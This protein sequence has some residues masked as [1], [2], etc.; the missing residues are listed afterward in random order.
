MDFIKEIY[1]VWMDERP[2]QLA[3]SVAFYGLFYLA[4]VIFIASYIANFFLKDLVSRSHLLDR[5]SMI[6][7]HEASATLSDMINRLSI[8]ST[9]GTFFTGLVS[10]I[11]L[12]LAASNLFVQLQ[13]ALNKIWD[14]PI[15]RA[16]NVLVGIT[17]RLMAFALV[18][19]VGILMVISTLANLIISWFGS[20]L[21]LSNSLP[22]VNILPMLVLFTL[23]FSSLYKILP[24]VKIRWRDVWVGGLVSSILV[25]LGGELIGFYFKSSKI[26]SAFEAAGAFAI[27]LIGIYYIAQIFLLG[28]IITRIY[29]NRYGSKRDQEVA[30]QLQ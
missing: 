28:A 2:A 13:Y 30:I 7:G 15:P 9:G 3:A 17:Q 18:I 21:G 20:F 25:I 8:P 16:D 14:A 27:I 26:S 22:F 1:R 12:L 6:F 4:P 24:N 5:I 19:G 23:S 29:A 11:A 10:T